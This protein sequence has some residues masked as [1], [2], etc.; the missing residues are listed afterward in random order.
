MIH[1]PPP[2]DVSFLPKPGPHPTWTPPTERLT[3]GRVVTIL[4]CQ[5][6]CASVLCIVPAAVIGKFYPAL[7][8]P[9]WAC[10]T[11]GFVAF[12]WLPNSETKK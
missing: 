10:F 4:I 1:D 8:Y 2:P 11:I 9:L 3:V 5:S 7:F 12:A 6:A